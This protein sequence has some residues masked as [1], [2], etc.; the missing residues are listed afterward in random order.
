[1][2]EAIS[3]PGR[4]NRTMPRI[5]LIED[6]E[7]NRE[8]L[9]RRLRRQGYDVESVEDAEEGLMAAWERRPDLILMDIGLPGMSGWDAARHLKEQAETR[10]IPIIALTA[11]AMPGDRERCLEA[12][13]DDY[14]TKPVEFAR[15]IDKIARLTP[16]LRGSVRH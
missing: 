7:A 14:E 10:P 16:A 1:M 12:G 9:E 4:L 13:C 8:M 2:P 11:H 6:N 5:L 15:L 3:L